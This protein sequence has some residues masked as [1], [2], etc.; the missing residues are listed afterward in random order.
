MFENFKTYFSVVFV[1]SLRLSL[2]LRV[3][4]RVMIDDIM[5]IML[6]INK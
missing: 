3:N 1:T 5:M 6:V 4:K 2:L